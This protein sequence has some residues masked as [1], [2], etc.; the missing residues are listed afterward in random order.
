[1]TSG[2]LHGSVS[3]KPLLLGPFNFFPK[4]LGD[5]LSSRCTTGVVD[6][7]SKWKKSV[8]RKISLFLLDTFELVKLA[9]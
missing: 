3:P 8:I 7:G 2:F 1:M 6:T 4:I 9:N 5:I